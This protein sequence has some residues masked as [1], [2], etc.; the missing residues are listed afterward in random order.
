MEF[1]KNKKGN[2]NSIYREFIYNCKN[3]INDKKYWRRIVCN[4]TMISESSSIA[5]EPGICN[6]PNNFFKE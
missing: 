1:V 2:F 3:V 5:K 6:H 4:V